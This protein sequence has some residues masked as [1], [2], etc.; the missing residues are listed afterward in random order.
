MI[1]DAQTRIHLRGRVPFG[2]N[3]YGND[4]VEQQSRQQGLRSRP[5]ELVKQ[6]YRVA[7]L[8]SQ[9]LISKTNEE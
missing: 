9:H 2:R 5:V 8:T 4:N 1:N 6:R 3:D 7:P